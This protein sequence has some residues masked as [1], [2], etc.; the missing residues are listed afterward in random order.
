MA[1]QHF[2]CLCRNGEKG[3]RRQTV[4]PSPPSPDTRTNN[5]AGLHRTPTPLGLQQGMESLDSQLQS[6]QVFG[7]SNSVVEHW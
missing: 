4:Q 5:P 6:A 1:V 7:K 3:T 2:A